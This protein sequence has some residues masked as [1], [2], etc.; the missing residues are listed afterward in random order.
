[1]AAHPASTA[2][3]DY[4]ER[5]HALMETKGYARVSDIAGELG[6]RP[7]SVSL[8]VQRLAKL[9]YLDYERYRGLRLTE[10][11]RAV[12]RRI[13]R[14]HAILERFFALIGVRRSQAEK[15]IEGIEHHLSA[16]TLGRLEELVD[17]LN[18]S[19]AN[20]SKHREPAALQPRRKPAKLTKT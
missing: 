20:P 12:A 17:R 9:G 8:M 15:D 14:R 10:E 19:P 2:A 11:G 7:P 6:L 1:M 13:Q 18:N 16:E 4:L 5:I 3:E